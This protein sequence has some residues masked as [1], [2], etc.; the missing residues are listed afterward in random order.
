MI[1][2]RFSLKGKV[3]IVTGAG[4]GIGKGIA[5]AFAEAGADLVCVARTV[6]Q[7]EATVTNVRSL[8]RKALAIRCDV[9]D[10]KQVEDMVRMA[11]REFGHIDILVNNAA[12]GTFTAAMEMSESGFESDLRL[13]LTS[14]FTC[15][16]AVARVMLEQKAGSII[17]ISSRES[18]MPSVGLLAYGA[19]KSG[20]NSLTKTLAWELA[21]HVRVNAILPGCIWTEVAAQRLGPFKDQ[22]IAATP[23]KRL[24]T[25]KDIALTALYLAS[26]ASD[27]VTGKLF[28]VDGGMEFTGG[29]A[30]H[31]PDI[32]VIEKPTVK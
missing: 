29:I 18:Q 16:K 1:F 25:P 28:E 3:A 21:P 11:R 10:G 8:G 32:L 23:L 15:S 22:I 27:W 26:S 9:Q 2:D 6:S 19:A 7:I 17:N 14:V 30:A 13:C 20:V 31:M 12:E 5:L 24:G 4:R